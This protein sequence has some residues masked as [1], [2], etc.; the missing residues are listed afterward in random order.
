MFMF[1]YILFLQE[2]LWTEYGD[3]T[4]IVQEQ[5]TYLENKFFVLQ[6][7]EEIPKDVIILIII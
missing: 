1:T 5:V 2:H 7:S 3:G 6:P 4:E